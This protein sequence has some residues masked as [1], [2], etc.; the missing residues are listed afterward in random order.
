MGA[1]RSVATGRRRHVSPCLGRHFLVSEIAMI[2][3]F[4]WPE[5]SLARLALL[6]AALLAALIATSPQARSQTL[7][8]ERTLAK[9]TPMQLA[10]RFDRTCAR[11]IVVG[12]CKWPPRKRIFM[13]VPVAYVETTAQPGEST[14]RSPALL[15]LLAAGLSGPVLSQSRGATDTTAEAHVYTLPDRLVLSAGL[16][17]VNMVCTPSDAIL[18]HPQGPA[19]TASFL[20]RDAS[21]GP[22][23]QVAQNMSQALLGAFDATVSEALCTPKPV[24]LSEID[25][26]NWRT[27]CGDAALSALMTAHSLTCEGANGALDF[28]GVGQAFGSLIGPDACL[29]KWGPLYPRQMRDRGNNPVAASARAAYR[30]LSLARQ[31]FGSLP[32]P[33]GLDGRMQQVYPKASLCFPPGV[34]LPTPLVGNVSDNGVYGWVYWRPATCCVP[35][36]GV[37]GCV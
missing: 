4:R 20:T 33:V 9:L 3:C 31:S 37:G 17:P 16:G 12:A 29:G 35:K 34:P 8:D 18:P 22:I 26:P 21:C 27:G 36:A 11:Q 15:P 14:V 2:P 32:F 10:A 7:F 25:V 30:A 5:R 24:Y 1:P 23:G 6:L 13:Y 28:I 19:D